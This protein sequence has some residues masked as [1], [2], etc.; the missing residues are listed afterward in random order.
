M[1]ENK[2][3]KERAL[4][5]ILGYKFFAHKLGIT[6]E[7][8]KM[9]SIDICGKMKDADGHCVASYLEGKLL[10]IKVKI[11]RSGS[12][13]GMLDILAHEMVHVAQNLR[14]EFTMSTRWEPIFKWIPFLKS[15]VN[16][17]TH[18][19]QILEDTPY[20]EMICEQE[21]FNKSR[22]L[23]RQFLNFMSILEN[24]VIPENNQTDSINIQN[25]EVLCS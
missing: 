7:E 18:A 12:D 1:F 9:V 21:A 23:T 3:K 11:L 20:Y 5:L 25:A 16:I 14:G 10:K 22:E 17:R 6:D 8:L 24:H 13:I 15:I 4:L 2:V 19:G